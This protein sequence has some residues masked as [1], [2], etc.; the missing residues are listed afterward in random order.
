MFC[1]KIRHSFLKYQPSLSFFFLYLLLEIEGYSQ[2]P[3]Q[4]TFLCF[5]ITGC[6]YQAAEGELAEQ[7]TDILF[8]YFISSSDNTFSFRNLLLY[9]LPPENFEDPSFFRILLIAYLCYFLKTPI[10]SLFQ[11]SSSGY[12]LRVFSVCCTGHNLISN[13]T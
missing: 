1:I 3:K 5:G 2:I 13:Q 10:F 7:H 9:Q 6:P 4:M 8:V 12:I 11:C